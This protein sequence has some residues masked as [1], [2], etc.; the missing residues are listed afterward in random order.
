MIQYLLAM[1]LQRAPLLLVL[2]GG[3]LFSI[4]RWKRH[5][6]VSLITLIGLVLYIVHFLVF[7]SLT[8]S[9]L[10]FRE[11]MHWSYAAANNIFE[12][13]NVLSDISFAIII[14]IMVTAAFTGRGQ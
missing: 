2:L 12:V 1:I 5:P 13:L 10:T 6:K 3:I 14:V 8:Y 11:T 4:V 9:V 7:T